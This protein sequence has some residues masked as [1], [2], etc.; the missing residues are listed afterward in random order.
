MPEAQPDR[1]D[2][3]GLHGFA[4]TIL[5]RI[6]HAQPLRRV[7]SAMAELH[8]LGKNFSLSCRPNQHGPLPRRTVGPLPSYLLRCHQTSPGWFW[9]LVIVVRSLKKARKNPMLCSV[10]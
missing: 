2:P 7:D 5:L 6:R 10:L 1:E 8:R 4:G 9:S 3:A